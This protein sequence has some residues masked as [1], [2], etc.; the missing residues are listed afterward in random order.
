MAGHLCSVNFN[1]RCSMSRVS[2]YALK[3][4][5]TRWTVLNCI[6]M[7]SSGVPAE[8]APVKCC[9]LGLTSSK[10]FSPTLASLQDRLRAEGISC[11][12]DE[13]GVAIGR[14]YARMDEIGVPFA[15]TV[16]PCGL[17]SLSCKLAMRNV[18]RRYEGMPCSRASGTR[19]GGMKRGNMKK[20][21][22][23]EPL[24]GDDVTMIWR[25]DATLRSIC[26]R[27][28]YWRIS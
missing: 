24:V 27:L 18:A 22:F 9:V 28:N 17:S 11:K 8:M 4:E 13:S 23:R 26:S 16:S 21:Q 7:M 10:E 15:I 25:T 12:V 3:S 1:Q 19:R 14:R 6:L 5:S 20:C 2:A